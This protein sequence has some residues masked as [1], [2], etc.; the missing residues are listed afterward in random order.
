MLSIRSTL[1]IRPTPYRMTAPSTEPIVAATTT[2]GT[3]SSDVVVIKPPKVRITSDG[4][5]G[6]T[7]SKAIISIMPK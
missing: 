4:M 1:R 2:P 3:V 7:F 6:N 5:G